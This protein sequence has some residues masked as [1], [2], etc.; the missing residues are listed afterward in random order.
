M[1]YILAGLALF[2]SAGLAKA[3]SITLTYQGS[4]PD[5]QVKLSGPALPSQ[6]SSGVTVYAGVLNWT[7]SSNFSTYCIDVNGAIFPQNTYT[8][9]QVDLATSTLFSP[10]IRSAIISLFAQHPAA[11]Y[12]GEN[13][14]PSMSGADAATF[15][16]A[17]WDIVENYLPDGT[18]NPGNLVFSDPFGFDPTVSQTWAQNAFATSSTPSNFVVQ[19]FVVDDGQ[20]QNQVFIVPETVNGGL[21]VPSPAS[22]AGGILLLSGLLIRRNRMPQLT[23]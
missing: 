7:G 8:F 11:G 21:P 13:I 15:Q 5:G 22:F 23:M 19:A 6:Y 14:T 18:P 16:T 20:G 3:S 17:L 10:T 9:T 2:L 1:R 12:V 4:G